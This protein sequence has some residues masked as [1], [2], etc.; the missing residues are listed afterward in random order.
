MAKF[1]IK[2]IFPLRMI[3][4]NSSSSIIH[5]NLSKASDKLMLAVSTLNFKWILILFLVRL[6]LVQKVRF[7]IWNER[8]SGNV[9]DFFGQLFH[10]RLE[11]LLVIYSGSS[12]QLKYLPW[13]FILFYVKSKG[14]QWRKLSVSERKHPIYNLASN[15][16]TSKYQS[17]GTCEVLNIL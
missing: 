10:T 14:I 4:W 12:H 9:P 17:Y 13:L 6:S 1:E 8:Y 5:L 16:V 11:Y 7:F 15:N 2:S 3:N